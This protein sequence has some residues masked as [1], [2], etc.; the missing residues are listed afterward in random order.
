MKAEGDQ[1][2]VVRFLRKEKTQDLGD[3]ADFR[4]NRCAATLYGVNSIVAMP[5]DN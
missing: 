3:H 5:M 2:L 1:D 4:L